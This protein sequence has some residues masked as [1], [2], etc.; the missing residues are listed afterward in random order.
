MDHFYVT[1][2]SDSSGYF[3]PNNT[4]ASFRTKLATPIESEHDKWVVG[5]VEV[6]YPKGYKKRIQYNTLRLDSTEINLPVEHY[7]SIY[8]LFTNIPQLS[9]SPKKEKIISI[10]G[11][12]LNIYTSHGGLSKELLGVCNEYNS[13]R[14]GEKVVSHFPVRLYN[15]LE[16]LAET[17]MN[18]ANCHTSRVP[19]SVNGSFNF[20]T[21][22]PVYVCTDIIKPDLVGD[23]YVR[24]LSSLHFPLGTG[25]H[26][27]DYPLY[28]PVEQSFI[29]SIAFR[30]VTKTG[31][32]VMFEDSNI[33]CLVVLHFKKKSSTQ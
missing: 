30:V 14:I 4:I 19:L 13:L 29:L 1:L 12:H 20:A 26:I 18:P 16:D 3:F 17:I 7:E 22:E 31:E 23:S 32:N 8:D 9:E 2:P 5:L 25:Y 6:S 21:P 27:F 11:N 24:L 28:K 15:E 33:P 10:F